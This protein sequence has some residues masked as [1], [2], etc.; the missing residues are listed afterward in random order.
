MTAVTAASIFTQNASSKQES[1]MMTLL[2][3]HRLQP[4]RIITKSTFSTNSQVDQTYTL[5]SFWRWAMLYM[6]HC[7]VCVWMLYSNHNFKL[8]LMDER[9]A[10]EIPE[11][12]E[13]KT[14]EGEF[15]SD[16]VYFDLAFLYFIITK[17]LSKYYSLNSRRT[18]NA[19][20]HLKPFN[21]MSIISNG[22]YVHNAFS[23]RL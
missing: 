23:K 4:P 16:F 6:L 22:I 14:N 8:K 5:A 19:V 20:V 15:K 17:T 7:F 9:G 18:N 1:D 12:A 11:C 3:K 13:C 21:S 10:Q 2:R